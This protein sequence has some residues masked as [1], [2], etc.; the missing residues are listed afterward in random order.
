MSKKNQIFDPGIELWKLWENVWNT[1]LDRGYNRFKQ[2][3]VR[4]TA[5]NPKDSPLVEE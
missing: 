2:K 1:Q 3:S 4:T 5:R